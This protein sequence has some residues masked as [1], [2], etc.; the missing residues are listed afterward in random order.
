MLKVP[1]SAAGGPGPTVTV[2]TFEPLELLEVLEPLEL[3]MPLE[4]LLL[5]LL[6][7]ELLLLELL[8]LELELLLELLV[9]LPEPVGLLALLLPPP[10]QPASTH[11]PSNR[12]QRNRW[13]MRRTRY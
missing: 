9:L 11:R 6:L 2:T 10:P 4:L 3:L 12:V 13:L 1:P 5:E 8:L 7:L